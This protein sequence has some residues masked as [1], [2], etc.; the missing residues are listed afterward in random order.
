MAALRQLRRIEKQASENELK[1]VAWLRQQGW[2]E[3]SDYPGALWLWSKNFPESEVQWV[4]RGAKR[5][6]HP[7][8]SINGAPINIAITIEAAWLDLWVKTEGT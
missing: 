3:S 8:F 7:A 5:I 4:W 2:K 6:P 1:R